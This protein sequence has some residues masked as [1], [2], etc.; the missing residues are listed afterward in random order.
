[1]DANKV[2]LVRLADGDRPQQL[3]DTTGLRE[4]LVKAQAREVGERI[5]DVGDLGA[6]DD[7]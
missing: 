3:F 2:L 7:V 6:F 5:I 4:V 1:M